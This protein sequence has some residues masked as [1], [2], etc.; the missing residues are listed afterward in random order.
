MG[1]PSSRYFP[2]ST[3]LGF[4]VSQG[5]FEKTSIFS[6]IRALFWMD[7]VDFNNSA[8]LSNNYSASSNK[9]ELDHVHSVEKKTNMMGVPLTTEIFKEK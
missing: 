2:K 3:G 7:M 9:P 4:K 8:R 5:N 1:L 6:F